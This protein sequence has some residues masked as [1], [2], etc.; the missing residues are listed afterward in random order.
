MKKMRK[1]KKRRC[2]DFKKWK[3]NNKK[4]QILKNSEIFSKL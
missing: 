4:L 3:K 2:E 1:A